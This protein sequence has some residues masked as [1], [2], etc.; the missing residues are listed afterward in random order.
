MS[1]IFNCGY[2]RG[3][4]VL[5]V[6]ETVKRVSGVNEKMDVRFSARRPGDPP[7]IVASSDKIRSRLDWTPELDNLSTIVEHALQWERSLAQRHRGSE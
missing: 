6:I 3:F 4:S 1:E 2:G 5:D 7:S